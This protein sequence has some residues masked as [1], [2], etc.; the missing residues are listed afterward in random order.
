[1]FYPSKLHDRDDKF[2]I[3]CDKSIPPNDII[4][5]LITTFYDKKKLHYI[6]LHAKVLSTKRIKILKNASCNTCRTI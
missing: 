3:L 6:A 5:K 4:K 1:M 2:P